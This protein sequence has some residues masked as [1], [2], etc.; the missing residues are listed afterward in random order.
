MDP[1]T[2]STH[3]FARFQ[4]LI[5]RLTGIHLA[6]AKKSLLCGR[7]G[8]RLKSRG[9][10]SY[11]EYYDL[12]ASGRDAQELETCINLITTNETYFFREPKHF[13][14][15]RDHILAQVPRG[16]PLRVWCA[17][18]S[19]GE[20]AYT[21][22]MV[23]AEARSLSAPWEVLASDIS[24]AVLRRA[25]AARYAMEQ[26]ERIARPLLQRYCLK[27][28][29]DEAGSFLIDAPLRQRVKFA[30]INLSVPLPELGQFDVIFL[31]NV[32]IYFP[33]EVKRAVVARL[34]A[35]LKPGGHL[36]VGHAETLGGLSEELRPVATTIYRKG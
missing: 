31:R 14:H 28:V 21:L 35:C 34:A 22:A 30:Q 32:M 11:G 33:P 4:R 17:A 23:L 5:H 2:I 13:E 24:T 27:G 1:T 15:L 12:V 7:L 25:V 6:E 29:G 36:F 10:A 16:Q 9:V 8:R 19:S 18:C 3:D 26:A 20:E